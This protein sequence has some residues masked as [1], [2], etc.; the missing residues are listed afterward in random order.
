MLGYHR[1][2]LHDLLVEAGSILS[3]QDVVRRQ[4]QQL[5]PAAK[6]AT[7]RPARARLVCARNARLK[8]RDEVTRTESI[9]RAH[10]VHFGIFGHRITRT[11]V[12][13]DA[14]RGIVQ[15]AD[16]Q[17]DPRLRLRFLD[18]D[19]DP[20]LLEGSQLPGGAVDSNSMLLSCVCA[21]RYSSAML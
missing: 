5:G 4:Q 20:H 7:D 10:F 9:E 16:P 6:D 17:R 1:G 18:G 14:R 11:H 8:R 3:C 12:L 15:L 2:R 21:C 13:D 19:R